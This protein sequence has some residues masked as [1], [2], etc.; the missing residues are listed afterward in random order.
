MIETRR[1]LERL[2]HTH[3]DAIRAFGVERIGVFGSFAR[4]E[5]TPA[6]DIDLMVVFAPGKKTYRNFIR[7][8]YYLEDLAGRRIELLTPEALSEHIRDKVLRQVEYVP[9]AA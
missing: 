9:L 1:D 5:Q 4:E 2:L 3:T 7:L 6:S 8:A